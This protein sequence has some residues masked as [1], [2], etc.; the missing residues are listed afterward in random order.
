MKENNPDTLFQ[1]LRSEKLNSLQE[2]YLN[3][4]KGYLNKEV[5]IDDYLIIAKKQELSL[6]EIVIN[7]TLY[8]DDFKR[9]IENK[10]IYSYERYANPI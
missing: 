2:E 7:N 10:M 9:E 3:F 4:E 1:Q 8:F 6:T 5:A